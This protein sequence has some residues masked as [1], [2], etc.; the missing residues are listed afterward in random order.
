MLQSRARNEPIGKEKKERNAAF[1]LRL[2]F[3][4]DIDKIGCYMV[5]GQQFGTQRSNASRFGRLPSSREI[6]RKILPS[7]KLLSFLVPCHRTYGRRAD[8]ARLGQQTRIRPTVIR[9]TS[10]ACSCC[11]PQSHTCNPITSHTALHPY[12]YTRL[13]AFCQISRAI[14]LRYS[15]S[16]LIKPRN[17]CVPQQEDIFARQD[18]LDH[19]SRLVKCSENYHLLLTVNK[20]AY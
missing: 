16:V 3:K 10:R 1:I 18:I 17:S 4:Q 11:L 5:Y 20:W 9:H 15:N 2:F 8:L 7:T 6:M 12:K 19:S 13:C 14:P